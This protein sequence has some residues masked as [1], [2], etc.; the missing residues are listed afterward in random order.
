MSN[1]FRPKTNKKLTLKKQSI[2]HLTLN[3]QQQ[4]MIVGGNVL[5][6]E[7]PT[8]LPTDKTSK[9]FPYQ[10]TYCTSHSGTVIA[11]VLTLTEG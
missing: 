4:K 6:T 1:P 8:E 3:D 7:L 10:E 2:A 5:P 11:T 9:I